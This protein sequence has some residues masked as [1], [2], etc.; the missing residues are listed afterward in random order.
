MDTRPARSCA[1]LFT[2]YPHFSAGDYW[3]DPDG[4]GGV[5]PVRVHCHSGS[6]HWMMVASIRDT[7]DDDAPNNGQIGA[8]HGG[9]NS[10]PGRI[11]LGPAVVSA[12]NTGSSAVGFDF[13]VAAQSQGYT[14]IRMC[15]LANNSPAECRDSIAGS[16]TQTARPSASWL[17]AYDSSPLLYTYGR[18]VGAPGSANYQSLT[19]EAHCIQRTAGGYFGAGTAT[20]GKLCEHDGQHGCASCRGVWNAIGAGGCAYNPSNQ[21]SNEIQNCDANHFAIYLGHQ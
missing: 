18:L 6:G 10:Q 4:V 1:D 2:R 16:L 21:G 19:Y 15:F 7:A 3:I 5:S 11:D 8:H 9:W 20:D 14:H 13:I 17:N 12:N